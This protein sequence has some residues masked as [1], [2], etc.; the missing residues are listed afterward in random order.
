MALCLGSSAM[1]ASYDVGPG[2]PL[3]ALRD[4]PWGALQPGDFVNIH[5]KS[6]GYHE[7]IQIS[8]SGSAAAHIVIRG[9]PDPVTGALPVIDGKD[10]V[11]DPSID[12]RTPQF[13]AWG[14]I[15]VSP[16]KSG[17]V[18]GAYHVSFVDI[19][20]LD[21]RNATYTG[22]G[23]ITFTDQFGVVKGYGGFACGIYIEWAHDLAVRG[24]EISNCGNGIFANSKNQ[25]AQSSQRL[26]IEKNYFH[27]NS[28]PPIPDPNNPDGL[29]ISNGFG[30]HHIYVESAG[31]IIQYNRF[32][33]LR[34]DAR[35]TAIKDRSSGQIIRY[36]EFDMDGESNVLAL[37]DP[38]GGNRFH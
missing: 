27:D 17:Y 2:Q 15:V 20:T 29:P 7:K 11:E 1:S 6:G 4:V 38:Q 8:A 16:R 10:A 26:L 33:K 37:M 23:S 30:E 3:A 31:S 12:Y 32:G 14:V 28:N 5:Y 18:Y 35:G 13:A 34:P 25:E 24:C 36:N 9:I 22:D 21:I 19:E